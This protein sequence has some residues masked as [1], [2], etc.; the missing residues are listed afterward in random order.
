MSVF[1]VG[2]RGSKLAL[3]QTQTVV[4]ALAELFP[5]IRF[6]IIKISS[7]GDRDR[8]RP[9]S[10]IGGSGLFTGEIEQALLSGDIDF[11][12]HSM[13]DLPAC[14]TKGL[15]VLS[16]L[17]RADPRDALVLRAGFSALDELPPG[18]RIGT[19]SPRR[20]AQLAEM[21]PDLLIVPVRGN[22]DTRIAKVGTELDG[23]VLAAAGLLR[24][25]FEDRISGYFSV[26]EMIPAPG[27]GI[28]A[29]ECRADDENVLSMLRKLADWDTEICAAA[30]R[31]F[32]ISSG[33]GCHAPVGAYCSTNGDKLSISGLY[34]EEGRVGFVCGRLEGMKRDAD[35][36]GTELAERLKKDYMVKCWK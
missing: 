32:L 9:L 35:K 13:K 34:G 1:K 12:V 22:V 3:I 5:Q 23:V 20:A 6:E 15:R 24:A 11:A 19:G 33:A 16:G 17:K 36:L 21:R 30:E 25:G 18:A 7:K 2:T 4:D 26:E 27:Q 29:L 31:A 8:V 14:T 10:E 28:L